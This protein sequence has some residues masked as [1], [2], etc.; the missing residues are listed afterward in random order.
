MA[1]A[2][3]EIVSQSELAALKQQDSVGPRS[4]ASGEHAPIATTCLFE[5]EVVRVWKQLVKPDERIGVHY[6]GPNYWL[7]ETEGDS[8]IV[9]HDLVNGKP[10]KDFRIDA[11]RGQG[12][13]VKGGK[14]EDA[15]VPSDSAS[16]YDAF[17]IELLQPNAVIENKPS[18]W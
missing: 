11:R 12:Y 5:N 3:K 9:G 13:F 15:G 2:T 14:L 17:V 6:H 18:V 8:H 16:A 1:E 10:T 4:G 7:L